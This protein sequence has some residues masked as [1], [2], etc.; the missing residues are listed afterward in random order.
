W[1]PLPARK[2]L[3]PHNPSV[4]PY[5]TSPT[6]CCIEMAGRLAPGFTREQAQAEVTILMNQF[7][8]Q[9][10]LERTGRALVT[11]TSWMASPRKKRQ[12]DPALALLF[13]AVTLV[14]LL[15]C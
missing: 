13:L 11:G 12:A 6:F 7:A 1:F 3:R 2:L 8:A 4:E 9:N 15:A 14:L 5:L 10:G